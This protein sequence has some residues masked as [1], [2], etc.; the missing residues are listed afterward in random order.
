MDLYSLL[1]LVHIVGAILWVGGATI[2]TILVLL[3]DRRNDDRETMA[4][5]T[6]L[7]LLGNRVFLPLSLLVILSGLILAWLGSWGFAA[8][9]VLAF[10]AVVGTSGL[11]GAVLGPTLERSIALW[12]EGRES[13]AIALCRRVLRLVKLDL[14]AQFAIIALMVLKPG[15][16]D[17]A[18]IVPAACVAVGAALYLRDGS[19][20]ARATQPA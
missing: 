10:V 12:K 9:T 11:G 6:H 16:T 3:I 14:A 13:E 7:G 1:K 15:W 2:M 4:A 19:A 5:V 20:K 8:W 18:L 17:T